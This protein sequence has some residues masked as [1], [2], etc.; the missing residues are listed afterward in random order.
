MLSSIY[1]CDSNRVKSD[2]LDCGEG[3]NLVLKR[4]ACRGRTTKL[5]PH[6]M[7]KAVMMMMCVAVICMLILTLR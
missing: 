3:K 5:T 6:Y 7:S 2:I 1:L 4:D